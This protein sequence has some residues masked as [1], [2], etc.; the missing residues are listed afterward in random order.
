MAKYG[1]TKDFVFKAAV[2]H[3]KRKKI[4]SEAV[5]HSLDMQSKAKAFT[6]AGYTSAEILQTFLD[7]LQEAVAE[8][9]T[10][11]QFR[12]TMNEYLDKNG[13]KGLGAWK[14]DTIFRQNVQT[15]FAVGHYQS[16]TDPVVKKLRPYWR[17]RTA[18]DNVVRDAHAVMDGK[19]FHADDPIW[20]I[21]YPPNGF[22]CRCIVTS[23]TEKQ[24]EKNGFEIS[25]GEK[26]PAHP[27]DG[28][29]V[30]PAKEEWQPDTSNFSK[31]VKNLFRG[32]KA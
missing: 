13:Y 28:F 2:E 24:V 29:G 15:A 4:L 5:Y 12:Q 27:D 22:R 21:W 3:L 30:N 32:R 1:L 26:I 18:G 9:Q 20:D 11:E 16:M 7:K 31:A 25:V 17:Y 14:S 23:L 6:V 8:G 10:K 19:V